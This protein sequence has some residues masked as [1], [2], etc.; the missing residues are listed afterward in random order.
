MTSRALRGAEAIPPF[1]NSAMDGY[2]LASAKAASA[3]AVLPVL[4]RVMAGDAP[5]CRAESGAWKIMT[6][7]PI[8]AGCDAVVPV[9]RTRERA[10]GREVEILEAPEAGDYVRGAGRDF[11]AGAEVCPAGTRLGPR[12]LLA[13]G[14]VGL[15]KVPVRKRPRV[16]LIATGKELREPGESLAPGQIRDASSGYLM[17]AL[18]GLGCE[19]RRFGTT[20]DDAD[21]FADR[22]EKAREWGA[23][24]V[25]TTG[26]VSM[27]DADFIPEALNDAGAETI[28]HKTAIRPGKPVL[29]ARLPARGLFFGLPGNPVSTVVGL[30]FFVEPALRVLLGRPEELPARA[31]LAAAAPKPEGLRCFFKARRLPDGRVEILPGQ[32]S[33]QI[34]SL[35]A[36]DGWA[37]LPEDGEEI[38]AGA[39]IE[40]RP[41]A[42]P[43]A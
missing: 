29:F 43:L 33:F 34:H 1:D 39:E 4:G 28:F 21:D 6:G 41:L 10:G 22:L 38:P 25:V 27:G 24:L 11:A 18:A 3:P 5:R 32:A 2:A 19:P 13:L 17:A 7:A 30:R 16:A 42:E 31:T 23:E 20:P 12:H 8:P 15:A 14:A 26:A 37:V 35:L 36:A 40:W 9:E